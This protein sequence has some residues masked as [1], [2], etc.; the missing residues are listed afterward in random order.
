MV[1]MIGEAMTPSE[2]LHAM[3]AGK[4]IDRLPCVPIMGNGAARV[5]G[6]RVAELRGNGPL[7]ARAQIEAYRLFRYDTVRIFTDL[8]V[9]A[10]AMGAIVH[11]PE[12]ETAY[13]RAPAIQ[14]L[15]EIDRLRP[16]DPYKDGYLPAQLEAMRIAVQEIGQEVPV[17]GALVGPFT[18]ATFL[19]GTDAILRDIYH[20]PEAVHRLCQLSLE[21]SLRYAE[22]MMDIGCT[23]SITD[24]M[25]SGS[26]ISRKAF[27]EF[28]FPYLK[29]LVDFIHSRGRTV[30]LHI[31]G[32]TNRILEGM[33]A[34]GADCLSLDNAVDL[35]E[36][37][38]RVGD[39]VR[40][41]GNVPP[42]EVMLEGSPA[43]VEAAVKRC[44]RAAG[45]NPKGFI[46]ASGCSLPTE[47]PFA[48]IQAMMAA[49]RR[50]GRW[51]IDPELLEGE[52]CHGVPD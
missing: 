43:D 13:L 19:R 32:N 40:L 42:A 1:K 41:M 24:A 12:D 37:K 49:V 14:S 2:R 47:T 26:V 38:R 27:E 34:T 15:D 52:G 18:N 35:A 50:Y 46:V 5:I 8:F 23:P 39:R 21:T 9:Q 20:H 36:A 33:A 16:A 3:A 25:S 11:C 29:K 31:C 7:L 45:D 4:S 10:E 28:S 17:T 22:A 30:T 51:P 6:V 44:L 48:N